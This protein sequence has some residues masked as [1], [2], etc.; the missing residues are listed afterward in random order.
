MDDRHL[1]RLRDLHGGDDVLEQQVTVHRVD[2]SEL[3]RLVVDHR[4]RRVLRRQQVIAE[5]ITYRQAGHQG[6]T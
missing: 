4:E 5:R 2:P 6:C 3:R 1:E